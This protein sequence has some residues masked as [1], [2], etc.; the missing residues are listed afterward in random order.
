MEYGPLIDK[1]SLLKRLLIF[2]GNLFF[3]VIRKIVKKE[4]N[5]NIVITSLHL[6][7]DSVLA[8]P[9]LNEIFK[10]Y[11]GKKI[12]I[13]SFPETKTIY[14]LAFES[15]S[16]VA[17][18]RKYFKFENRIATSKARK[19]LKEL[20]PEIIFDIT[21]A[22]NSATLIFNS[23]ASEIYGLKS[24]SSAIFTD[25]IYNKLTSVRK[26]PHL[27]D[28][29]LD[30]P[31]FIFPVERDR[32]KIKFPLTVKNIEKILIHPFAGWK[33]KEWGLEKFIELAVQ[34]KKEYK[35]E[36]VV[37]SNSL[38][39][40]VISGIELLGVP[41]YQSKSVNDLITKIKECSLLIGCDSGPIHI[42]ALL[43]KLTL[44]VFGPTNPDYI[45][46][47]G[48]GHFFV[49]KEIKCS[50]INDKYCYTSAGRF[51]PSY[52]CMLELSVS[53]VK[54]KLNELFSTFYHSSN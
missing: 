43:G 53:D 25:K 33:A 31:E 40:D 11:P 3:A 39:K 26:T 29:Y 2:S 19:I 6:L 27:I 28:M 17:I 54:V 5:G 51:C 13:V 41:V 36:F 18:N 21:G 23:N 4:R 30:V 16:I 37:P 1:I 34:L 52:L 49:R 9:A 10:N 47:L 45:S 15:D 44:A 42:A 48:E 14:E 24:M 35:V 32:D 50:P 20:K 12:Y 22:I 8:I 7:G 46:P 38:E